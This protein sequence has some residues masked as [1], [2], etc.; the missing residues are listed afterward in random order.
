VDVYAGLKIDYSKAHVT[1]EIFQ[2]VLEGNKAFVKG[3]G[4]E[5]VLESTSADNVFIFFSDHGAPGLIAF[6]SKY[7]YADH[8]LQSFAKMNG[9]YKKLVFY[10]EVTII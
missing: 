4:T 8:L 5:R 3:K 10:L 1:P 2:A 9:K 7:L 6:P